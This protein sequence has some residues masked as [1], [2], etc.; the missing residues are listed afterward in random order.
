MLVWKRQTRKA[1]CPN[2]PARAHAHTNTHFQQE[3]PDSD[4]AFPPIPPAFR[5]NSKPKM[6][7]QI[8]SIIYILHY[9][10][11]VFLVI[12]KSVKKEGKFL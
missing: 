1:P 2:T 4:Q 5:E 7:K 11:T 6:L 12:E 9:F 10:N 3:L 8:N